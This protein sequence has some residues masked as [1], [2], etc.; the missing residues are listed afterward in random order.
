MMSILTQLSKNHSKEDL[1]IEYGFHPSCFGECFIA[2]TD[3]GI[4]SLLFVDDNKAEILKEFKNEWPNAQIKQSQSK[5]K[6]YINR[7]F[8][9]PKS[10]AMKKPI[11]LLCKGTNFQIKVWEALLK[12]PFGNVTSYQGIAKQIGSPKA[13]RAVGNAVGKNPI[14]YLIPCHRVIRGTGQIGGY[15]WGVARK[16]VMLE[17]ESNFLPL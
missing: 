7:I 10:A 14:S 12:I 16:K 4:C 2:L 11:C 9:H 8:S 6:S 17:I 3:E 1:T 15:R 13:M 5:A